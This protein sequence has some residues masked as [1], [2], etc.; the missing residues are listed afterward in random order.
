MNINE[1]IGNKVSWSCRTARNWDAA[2]PPRTSAR[3][4][5]SAGSLPAFLTLRGDAKEAAPSIANVPQCS[6]FELSEKGGAPKS[7]C[8]VRGLQRGFSFFEAM[9]V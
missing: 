4:P 6:E 2:S 8:G 1:L 9:D 5:R 7:T 3:K